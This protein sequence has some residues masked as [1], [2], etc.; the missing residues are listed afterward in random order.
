MLTQRRES[1]TSPKTGHYK[2]AERAAEGGPHKET[3]DYS[4]A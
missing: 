4:A 3:R 1:R 2:S